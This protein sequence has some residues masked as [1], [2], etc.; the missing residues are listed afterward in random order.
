MPISFRVRASLVEAPLLSASTND[1]C[2]FRVDRLRPPASLRSMPTPLLR[3]GV[4]P[5]HFAYGYKL[6]SH[7]HSHFSPD[8]SGCAYGV[9]FVPIAVCPET[10]ACHSDLQGQSSALRPPIGTQPPSATILPPIRG[11]INARRLAR[12]TRSFIALSDSMDLPPRAGCRRLPSSTPPGTWLLHW[13]LTAQYVSRSH[14]QSSPT[15]SIFG[16][17]SVAL[18]FG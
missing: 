9:G 16:R 11:L 3:H 5:L 6:S 1:R 8:T 15:P 10:Y 14:P 13:H 17:D 18:R 2:G 7:F 12:G 4:G